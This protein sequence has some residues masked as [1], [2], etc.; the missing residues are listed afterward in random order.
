MLRELLAWRGD[1]AAEEQLVKLE[2]ALAMAGPKL[3]GAVPLIAPLLSLTLPAKYLPSPLSPE[4]K[5]RRL[6]AALIELVLAAARAQP[7]VIV[8]EDLHWSDP[9]TLE[10]IQLLVEQ[11]LTTRLPLIYTAR[12]E[13]HSQWPQRAHHMCTT[14]NRLSAR[15]ARTIVG[16]V[17]ERTALSDE[18]VATVVERTGGVPLFLEELTRAILES[19]DARVTGGGIPATLHDSLM[20]RLD[21][22]GSAR[23]VA[24]VG[25]AIGSEFS[26]ELLHAVHPV[27]EE[28][29]QKALRDLV[30]AELLYERGIAPDA[31]YRF[32]HA[33]IRDA[34]YEALLISRRKELHRKV[35][36]TIDEQFPTLK[37]THPQ[38]LARHWTEAGEIEPAIAAWAKAGKSAESRNAFHEALESYQ[39]A[40]DLLNLMPKSAG[41]DSRE[42]EIRLLVAAMLNITR[43]YAARE[44]INAVENAI[45]LAERNG[46]LTQLANLL[47][48]RGATHLISGDFSGA[49]AILDRAVELSA[50]QSSPV[51]L[52]FLHELQTIVRYCRGDLEGAEKHFNAWCELFSDCS[53]VQS[54]PIAVNALA[55]GG[56]NAWVRGRADTA[57]QRES[58]M[59]AVANRGTP[60][61][62]ANSRYCAAQLEVYFREYVRAEALSMHA[63][64]LGEKHQFPNPAAR[65][66]GTLGLARAHLDRTAEGVALIQQC[67]AGLREIGT[68]MGITTRMSDL[69]EAQGLQGCVGDALETVE[70]A[71]RILP[72]ELCH[73]PETLRVR[74]ELRLKQGEVELGE[75]SYREAIEL[76]QTMGAK[77]WELRATMSLARLLRDTG[78]RDDARA[79]LAAIYNWFTEGFDTPDLKDAQTLLAELID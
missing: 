30:S 51:N 2:S 27:A 72:D 63:V 67:L 10:L 12:P 35:A 36:S 46:D 22:L 5:R 76:A 59:I 13:F 32:K 11:G 64:E 54:T 77:A 16:E 61:D 53:F 47:T 57:R 48:S 45:A 69:A 62:V 7:L 50:R 31:I 34:A 4:Q 18:T 58:Q 19:G 75:A 1:E 9:S 33:L 21:R 17:A 74:G 26:Y 24:Q 79:R 37:E 25:A 40:L 41:R 6:L 65:G 70:L 71:L 56:L 78:R 73:R 20:A 52:P 28:G 3:R 68:R 14:L 66:R 23:E 44:T 8:T 38:V 15:D 55:F 49:A 39:Q 42:M 29:L 43:G 60:F